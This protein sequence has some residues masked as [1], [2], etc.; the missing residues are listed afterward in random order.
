MNKEQYKLF[1][2]T[3]FVVLV[4]CYVHTQRRLAAA[5]ERALGLSEAEARSR[6]LAARQTAETLTAYGNLM[7]KG[8]TRVDEVMS[9]WE[10]NRQAEA[11][12]QLEALKELNGKAAWPPMGFTAM[13]FATE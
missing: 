12:R 8:L 3:L 4:A 5:A 9:R 11:D 13:P 10:T 1:L 7:V 6:A 2:L